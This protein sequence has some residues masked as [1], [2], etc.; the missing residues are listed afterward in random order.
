MEI[1]PATPADIPALCRLLDQLFAQEAEFSPDRDAQQRGLAAI[2]EQPAAGE[3]LLAEE[4][5]QVL[6]MVNLLYTI[7]TAL[8]APVALLEDM[9]VDAAARDRGLGTQLLEAAI[10]TARSRG[11]RR[12]TLLTDTDNL[13]AQRFYARR[14]F[15]RSPMIPLRRALDPL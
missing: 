15:A 7:S 6:A 2:I 8:G 9:V 5:G 13:D 4:D 1:R 10:A 11:C 12:I 14:G 3:I